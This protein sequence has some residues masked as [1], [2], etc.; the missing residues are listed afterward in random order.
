MHW[1]SL[2]KLALDLS[3]SRGLPKGELKERMMDRYFEMRGE[4]SPYALRSVKRD[5]NCGSCLRD[6]RANVMRHFQRFDFKDGGSLVLV[7]VDSLDRR[8][9]Y[10]KKKAVSD[11]G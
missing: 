2:E 3:E 11:E 10:A 6:V 5:T 7:N 8:P 9:I 4:S 1:K